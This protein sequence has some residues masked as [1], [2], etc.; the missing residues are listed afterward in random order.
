M[1]KYAQ[2]SGVCSWRS[3]LAYKQKGAPLHF[4]EQTLCFFLRALLVLPQRPHA[5]H[6]AS[7]QAILPVISFT[8]R[9][10]LR[11]SGSIGP[12]PWYISLLETSRHVETIFILT[13]GVINLQSSRYKHRERKNLDYFPL[14]AERRFIIAYHSVPGVSRCLDGWME[15]SALLIEPFKR[16]F[17]SIQWSVNRQMYAPTCTSSTQ[18][19]QTQSPQTK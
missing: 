5:V 15:W 8:V 11:R 12:I 2:P 3:A 17:L 4:P 7:S 1:N 13:Q 19:V 18:P 16:V 6:G 14:C 9:K 10:T